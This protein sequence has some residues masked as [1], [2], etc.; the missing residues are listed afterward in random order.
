[1]RHVE[2]LRWPA[3]SAERD[4]LARRGIACLLLIQDGTEAPATLAPSEDWIRLPASARDIAVRSDQLAERFEART[5]PLP[6]LDRNGVL[7]VGDRWQAIPPVEGALMTVLIEDFGNV[8]MRDALID[9]AWPG[10]DVA[11]NALDVRILRLR[12]RVEPLGLGVRTIRS[13]G[14]LLEF[15]TSE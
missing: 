9:A 11:R 15:D 2:H 7:R 8:V 5:Q 13:R 3:Q 1:M 10:I 6:V 4:D 14:Y 12:R